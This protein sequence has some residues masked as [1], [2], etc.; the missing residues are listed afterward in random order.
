MD[1]AELLKD[2]GLKKT[3]A[4]IT[5]SSILSQ[6]VLPLSEQDIKKKMGN[7][8]DRVTFYRTVQVLI[9]AGIIHRI[10]VDNT[11][12]KYAFTKTNKNEP[13][14]TEH[15]HFY[16]TECHKLSCLENVAVAHYELPEGYTQSECAVLIKG[17]CKS[18]NKEQQ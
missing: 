11:Q 8:Y 16:C 18:C 4:R 17:I 7:D 9:E 13:D 10:I 14:K 2:K 3:N 12:I 15:I 5:I 1:I 6:S